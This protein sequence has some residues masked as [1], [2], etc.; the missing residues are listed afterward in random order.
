MTYDYYNDPG[1]TTFFGHHR[2]T[3]QSYLSSKRMT[4]N[5]V[6]GRSLDADRV[7]YQADLGYRVGGPWRLS[8]SYTYDRYLG[9]SYFDA[10]GMLSYNAGMRDIGLTYSQRLKRFGVQILGANLH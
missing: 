10:F 8:Y 7:N 4:L 9:G 3:L 2:L 1:T 6:T 5:L